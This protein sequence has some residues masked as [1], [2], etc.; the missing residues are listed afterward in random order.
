[1][2]G[3]REG[4]AA[5]MT[6]VAVLHGDA[7]MPAIFV[8]LNACI[9]LCPHCTAFDAWSHSILPFRGRM[10]LGFSLRVFDPMVCHGFWV[11]RLM[12][13]C[14]VTDNSRLEFL[15]PSHCTAGSSR[16][17]E[18][19]GGRVAPEPPGSLDQAQDAGC[20]RRGHGDCT[21][22]AGDTSLGK[23]DSRLYDQ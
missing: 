15:C 17:V 4:E 13:P 6:G 12:K 3:A 8:F 23:P 11:E 7:V 9:F 10:T 19:R 18:L 2:T 21:S 16:F 14:E 5:T 1:M 22:Q 20:A